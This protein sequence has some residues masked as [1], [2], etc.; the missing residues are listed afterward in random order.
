M[1]SEFTTL[2]KHASVAVVFR[3]EKFLMIKRAQSVR[4]PGKWCFPGG[5]V[6]GEETLEAA[7][8]R[9]MNEELN[10]KV[11]PGREVW[12]SVSSSVSYTHLT[13]PTK[14]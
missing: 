8:I 11:V 1:E 3:D 10:V 12:R 14:A 6:E 4:A 9:E 7:L 13:L 2:K 5:G